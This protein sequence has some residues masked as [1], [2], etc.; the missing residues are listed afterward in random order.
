VRKNPFNFTFLG[1]VFVFRLG[2]IVSKCGAA[3][4]HVRRRPSIGGR[5]RQ[6]PKLYCSAVIRQQATERV[7]KKLHK[8][9]RRC[10][11]AN[12]QFLSPYSSFAFPVLIVPVGRKTSETLEVYLGLASLIHPEIRYCTCQWSMGSRSL[13]IYEDSSGRHVSQ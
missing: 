13:N 1:C 4:T 2:R 12:P 11:C 5:S 10:Q 6:A 7:W 3:P 8:R 9:S